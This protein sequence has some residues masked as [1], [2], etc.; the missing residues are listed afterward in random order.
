RS[1]AR[2]NRMF[3]GFCSVFRPGNVMEVSRTTQANKQVS[4]F[5]S[6]LYFT[7]IVNRFDAISMGILSFMNVD[8]IGPGPGGIA[9]CIGCFY[10]YVLVFWRNFISGGGT[11]FNFLF[12]PSPSTD[13]FN[14]TWFV[15]YHG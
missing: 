3:G 11:S 7:L 4:F 12:N 14:I 5:M 6:F 10:S 15:Q 9:V 2:M 8:R 13:E 1:S